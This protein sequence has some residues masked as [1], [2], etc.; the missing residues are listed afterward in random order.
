MDL[1]MRLVGAILLFSFLVFVV[2]FGQIPALRIPTFLTTLD[3]HLTGG[4][5]RPLMQ[6]TGHYL[7]NENHPIILVSCG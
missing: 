3:A 4:R 6:Q 5:L 2:L 7:M 1:I